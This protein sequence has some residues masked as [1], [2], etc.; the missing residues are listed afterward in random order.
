MRR[1]VTS[2]NGSAERSFDI[3]RAR[4]KPSTLRKTNSTYAAL[5]N[6]SYSTTQK[7][8]EIIRKNQGLKFEPESPKKEG[9]P[10]AKEDERTKRDEGP[11]KSNNFVMNKP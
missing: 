6:C 11:I 5:P 10:T 1:T 9:S 4:R 8:N 3:E 7:I 2:Q